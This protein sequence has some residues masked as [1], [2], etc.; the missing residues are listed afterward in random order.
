MPELPEVETTRRGIAPLVSGKPLREF[1]VREP[2]L[3]WPVPAE[4]PAILPGHTLLECGRRGKYL[5]LRFDHGVQIVHLGMSGALRVVARDAFLRPHDHV[6]WDFGDTIL[7]LHDPRRFGAVLWHPD[8]GTPVEQH[9]LLAHLGI[10]PFDPRFDGNWLHRHFTGKSQAI[11][12][13]LLAGQAVVGVGNIYASESLFRA[14]IH[15]ATPA[16]KLSLPRCKRLAA[17]ITATLT[18]A[19]ASGGSTLR[20]Y[21]NPDSQPGAYFDIHAAVYD[22]EGQPC[23]ICSTAIK[24]I[25]QGQRA[26]YYCPRCQRS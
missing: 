11:K 15:P 10:E 12:Q 20:D 1:V 23:R 22:R 18:D 7:R 25:V 6:E 17:A 3:R 14:R 4:L 26:T 8:G 16:G 9:P 24:R 5:L 13:A 19:L 2:R 21:V